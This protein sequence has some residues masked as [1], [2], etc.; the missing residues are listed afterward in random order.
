MYLIDLDGTMYRESMMIDGAKDF[1]DECI[2]NGESFAFLTNNASRTKQE[3]ADHMLK[4]GFQGIKPE[5][6][7]TSAMGAARYVK[8]LGIGQRAFYIGQA[9]LKEALLDNDFILCDSDV[10]VVFVGLD[11][12]ADYRMYSKALD[13]LLKGAR[14]IGTNSDRLIAQPSGFHMGNGAIVKMFEYASGQISPQ[15]GKPYAPM[16]S[17]SMAYFK[18]N[19][20]HV[21]IIG[22][23]LETDI[24][25][26]LTQGINSI[27]VT[28]GVHNKED[29]ER[30]QIHPSKVVE[31]LKEL[32]KSSK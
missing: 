20:N 11:V 5:Q 21:T 28:S 32:L 31:N 12:H 17:E 2:A 24:V 16:L 14:L 3:N 10:Q 13:F 26:G 8:H 30:M 18:C 22:D 19:K 1:I 4:M 7:F 6:F 15:I 9:G 25:M 27:F 23:N 29:M